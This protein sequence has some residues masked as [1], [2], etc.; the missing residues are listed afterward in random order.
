LSARF[1]TFLLCEVKMSSFLD[2]RARPGRGLEEVEEEVVEAVLMR[3]DRA[4][5]KA[6]ELV[7][8]ICLV[9]VREAGRW[10]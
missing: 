9:F 5:V 7:D 3:L 1:L 4:E 2:G 8:D 6:T 10:P